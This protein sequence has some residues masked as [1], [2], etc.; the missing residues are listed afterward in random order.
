[1]DIQ[2]S[3]DINGIEAGSTPSLLCKLDVPGQV[4][5]SSGGR[6]LTTIK[7]FEYGGRLDIK[8]ASRNDTGDYKCS[9]QTADGELLEKDIHIEVIGNIPQLEF[10]SLIVFSL[11]FG[12]TSIFLNFV[13]FSLF[14]FFFFVTKDLRSSSLSILNGHHDLYVVFFSCDFPE[15]GKII[16][17][18]DVRAKVME[19]VNLTCHVHGYPLSD[20]TWL[21]GNDSESS[22]HL[23]DLT[24]VAQINETYSVL[25]LEFKSLARKDNGTYVCQAKDYNGILGAAA[26]LFVI[27]VPKVSIDFMKAV[28][29]GSIFLNW[30]VNDGNEPIKKYFIQHMKKGTDQ[31]QYYAEQIGG[32]NSSYVLKGFESGTAYQ[33]GISATNAVGTS[34]MQLDPRWITTLDKGMYRYSKNCYVKKKV[35]LQSFFSLI[36]VCYCYFQKIN[37]LLFFYSKKEKTKVK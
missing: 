14:L 34:Y 21:K 29:A 15:P 16:S 28:G 8:K 5:W 20:F 22:E 24:A 13:S 36:L 6:N 4:W 23:K 26:H 19:A 27:D 12:Y 3:Q 33:I 11:S 25:I 9:A 18:G 37:V 35:K 7:D 1:M 30:T 2:S 10:K 32:G 17:G 31:R